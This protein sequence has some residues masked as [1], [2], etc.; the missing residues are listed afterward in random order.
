MTDKLSS[1]G[2]HG[3]DPYFSDMHALFRAVGPDFAHVKRPHFRNVDVYPLLCH[4]LGIAPAPC[5]GDFE[6]IKDLLK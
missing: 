4:L 3:F 5:D 2:T 1:Y 6:E